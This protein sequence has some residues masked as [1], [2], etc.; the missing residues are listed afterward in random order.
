MTLSQAVKA[1]G[2]EVRFL[3]CNECTEKGNFH[4]LSHCRSISVTN[5]ISFGEV[6]VSSRVKFGK[7]AAVLRGTYK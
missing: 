4:I 3:Q 6:S 7:K 1:L 2:V 5:I